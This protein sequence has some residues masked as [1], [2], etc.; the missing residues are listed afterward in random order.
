MGKI[1]GSAGKGV[2]VQPARWS[3]HE[4]W[5]VRQLGQHEFTCPSEGFGSDWVLV[6]DSER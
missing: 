5:H 4:A 2:V 1:A 3:V 6:L